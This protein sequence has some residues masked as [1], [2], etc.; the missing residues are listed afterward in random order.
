MIRAL[1]VAVALAAAAP[2][3]AQ[4][5]QSPFAEKAWQQPSN[6]LGGKS[7]GEVWRGIREGRPGN[8]TIP[9]KRAGVMIQSQGW[10]WRNWRN[11]LLSTYGLWGLVG[12]VGLLALFF[13]VRGRI[14][15]D[16]G[17]S[18][19]RILRFTLIERIGH[20]LTAGSFIL[21]GLTG[22]NL[23]YGKHWLLPLIG[24]DAFA[25]TAEIGKFVHNWTSWLFMAGLAMIFVMWV[26]DNLWD[27][28]D[29]G[30]L[31]RGGGLLR[32][33][34][35]PPAGKFNFGQK[36][37]FWAVILGGVAVSVTGLGLLF[38]FTYTTLQDLQLLQIAHASTALA[39]TVIILAHI[40]IGS[41]GMEGAFDA[42]ASGMVDENWAREHH[43][44]WV[45]QRHGRPPSRTPTPGLDK[46]PAE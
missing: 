41:I 23:L 16:A 21:L 32:K 27:R 20:W 45:D 25:T 40:Y 42:M 9:D 36:L 4:D 13:L 39:L 22:L 33:G 1:L 6:T 37:I 17:P 43:A 11:G 15:I 8:V 35:H 26:R 19:R 5:Y 38:P 34:S 3:A 2:A 24:K 14:R 12:M 28:Y 46:Q 7:D 31:I 18:G 10:E 29:W 44:A 30:W